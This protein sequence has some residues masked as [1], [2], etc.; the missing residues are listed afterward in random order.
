MGMR[1]GTEASYL[2]GQWQPSYVEAVS[3]S[4]RSA[5][6]HLNLV[7]QLFSQEHA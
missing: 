1:A 4:M 3:F 7:N 6:K 2:P 5:D